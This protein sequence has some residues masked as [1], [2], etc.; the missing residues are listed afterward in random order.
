M[1][2]AAVIIGAVIYVTLI[3]Q[4]V[5]VCLGGLMTTLA[6]LLLKYKRLFG[7]KDAA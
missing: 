3:A 1:D 4:V 5:L 6:W 7:P 2:T